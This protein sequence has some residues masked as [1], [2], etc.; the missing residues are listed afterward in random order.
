MINLPRTLSS[1]LSLV[2]FAFAIASGL[3]AVSS[4]LYARAIGGFP[5]YDPLLLRI[6]RWGFL[7]SF[8]G[9]TLAT[10]GALRPRPGRLRFL[11]VICAAVTLIFWLLTAM[12]E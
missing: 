1:N 3:L 12:G 2:G 7:L 10:I 9:L 4:M 6:F 8:V 5:F 11:P